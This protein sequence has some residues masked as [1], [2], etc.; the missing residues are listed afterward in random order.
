MATVKEL[1]LT[2]LLSV[3]CNVYCISDKKISP[4]QT[5]KNKGFGIPDESQTLPDSKINTG[6]LIPVREIVSIQNGVREILVTSPGAMKEIYFSSGCAS[7]KA[8]QKIIRTEVPQRGTDI[9]TGLCSDGSEDKIFFRIFQFGSRVRY[10]L[11]KNIIVPRIKKAE[12]LTAQ[13]KSSEALELYLEAIEF[14]PA[15]VLSRYRL[16][17]EYLEKNMCKESS[18]NLKIFFLLVPGYGKTAE[19]KSALKKKCGEDGLD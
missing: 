17:I 1:S 13:K 4:G 6:D 16:G 8:L 19:I 3:F 7:G 18:R 5:L 11:Y 12:K 2:L 14:E 10:D 15:H 9:W